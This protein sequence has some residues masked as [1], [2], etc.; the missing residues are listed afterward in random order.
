MLKTTVYLPHDLKGAVEREARQRG[1]SEATVIR[2]AIAEAVPRPVPRAGLFQGDVRPASS[3]RQAVE[4]QALVG[5]M[6]EQ[7]GVQVPH[8]DRVA[9][10]CRLL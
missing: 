2:E 8:V 6:A 9:D 7:G 3:L 1:V 10:E 5:L 4:H